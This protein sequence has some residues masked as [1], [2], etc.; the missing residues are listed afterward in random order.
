MPP[1]RPKKYL[2]A[3]EGCSKAYNRPLLLR[4]HERTHSNDRPFVCEEEGCKKSFL[5]K[6]HLQVHLLSHCNDKEKPFQCAVCGKGCISRPLLRRHE[7]THTD[8]RFKCKECGLV[9]GHQQTLK[10]HITTVHQQRLTC[11]ICN[12]RFQRPLLLNEHKLK[13]HGEALCII[14]EHPGCFENFNDARSLAA[15]VKTQHGNKKCPTCGKKVKAAVY[16]AHLKTHVQQVSLLSCAYCGQS[17]QFMRKSELIK[18]YQEFHDNQFPADILTEDDKQELLKFLAEAENFSMKLL[19]GNHD[20]EDAGQPEADAKN[21][22]KLEA[23]PE[24]K[25][26]ISLV[27]GNT[28][29][30]YTCPKKHCRRTFVRHHAFVKHL[31]WHDIHLQKIEEFLTSLDEE[32]PEG[33]EVLDHFSD[34]DSSILSDEEHSAEEIHTDNEELDDTAAKSAAMLLELDQLLMEELEKQ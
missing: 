27:L 21:I 29:S 3:F 14:C 4:Q 28:Q 20:T 15:H 25:S 9:V 16:E 12:R 7:L 17:A 24:N 22:A 19:Q 10:H 30:V 13:H 33:G 6:S 23:L 11:L 31:D 34:L 26:V 5:R 32:A 8:E 1:N 18:H 2:C